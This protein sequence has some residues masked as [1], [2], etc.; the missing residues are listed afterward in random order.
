MQLS[1]TDCT[2]A[3]DDP[4]LHCP[5]MTHYPACQGSDYADANV[6]D[7]VLNEHVYKQSDPELHRLI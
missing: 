2:N 5:H 1:K 6:K 3:Q 7:V 4:E